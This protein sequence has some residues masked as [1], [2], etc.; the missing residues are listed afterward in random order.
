MPYATDST[1]AVSFPLRTVDGVEAV[2]VR[3]TTRLQTIQ[4]EWPSDTSIGLPWLDWIEAGRV[5]APE[6]EAL[7]RGQL[8]DDPAVVSVDAVTVATTGEAVGITVR[9]TIATEGASAPVVLTVGPD[10][11][12]TRAAPPWYLSSGALRY[13]RGALMG[14]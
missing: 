11:Y 13:T 3:L 6:A 8:E 10:P 14:A 5:A 7:V 1:G 12:A 2:I 4:G 9:A